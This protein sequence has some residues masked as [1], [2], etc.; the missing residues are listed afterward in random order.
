MVRLSE[1]WSDAYLC[2]CVE[3]G[4]TNASVVFVCRSQFF[5]DKHLSALG[6]K[7]G[8]VSLKVGNTEEPQFYSRAWEKKKKTGVTTL[9]NFWREVFKLLQLEKPQFGKNIPNFKP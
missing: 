4:R 9:I 5:L 2:A 1:V 3:R 6:L 7:V 8:I